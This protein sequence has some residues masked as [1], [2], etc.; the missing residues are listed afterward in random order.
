MGPETSTGGLSPNGTRTCGRRDGATPGVA[1]VCCAS[2]PPE[3]KVRYVSFDFGPEMERRKAASG[4]Y[5]PPEMSRVSFT[6][7][8]RKAIEVVGRE[9]LVSA[10]AGSGKTA[11]LAERCA[12][13]VCDAPADI[14][15]NVDELLVLTFT[16]AAAAEMRARIV[17]AI[18][19]RSHDRPEDA[20]LRE[21]LA[22]A[23]SAQIS[24]V[25]SF[26]LWIIR[27]WFT[28]AEVDPTASVLSAEEAALL[29]HE[30]MEAL[31]AALYARGREAE[32]P[33]AWER[34][35]DLPVDR[36]KSDPA[37]TSYPSPSGSAELL[38]PRFVRLVDDYGLG[39]DREIASL[40]QRLEEFTGSLPDPDAWF[41]NSLQRLNGNS[42]AVLAE[43][44][45]ELRAELERQLEA[46]GL[47]QEELLSGPPGQESYV[48]RIGEYVTAMQTW[49]GIMPKDS[50]DDSQAAGSGWR[51]SHVAIWDAVQPLILDFAFSKR[52]APTLPRDAPESQRAA[53]EKA[54]KTWE[55]VRKRM[56]Q[57]RIRD[58]FG[59]FSAREWTDGLRRIASAAGTLVDLVCAFRSEYAA[60]KQAMHVVDFADLERL[61]NRVIREPA[62]AD[63]LR[64]RFRFVL[65]DE[66]QD[67]NPLQEAIIRGVCRGENGR[68]ENL[69]AVGDIKQSIYR[70]R[71]AEPQV[72]AER[73][74]QIETVP[75]L[76]EAVFLQ[77]NFRS[78]PEILDAVN[79]VF[80]PLMSEDFGRLAY[81]E[82]VELRAGA[83]R[84]PTSP[85]VPVELHLIE[86]RFES[87]PS[88][89]DV[90]EEED[91]SELESEPGVLSSRDASR[92]EPIER[93][94]HLI[95][96]L[97]R[98]WTQKPSAFHSDPG[99]PLSRR[100]MVILLRSARIHAD[101]VAGMLQAMGIP[102][103]ADAGS[104][105]LATV[106]VRDLLAAL[107]VLDNPR[108][109][110]P[111]ASALRSGVFGIA[112]TED[113]LVALRCVDRESAFHAAVQEF[114]TRESGTEL[115]GKVETFWRRV[116]RLRERARRRPLADV[117]TDLYSEHGN[118]ARVAAMPRGFQRQTNLHRLHDLARRFGNFR[119]Q[120]LH[121][122][123]RFVESLDV[124]E[125]G[126][127]VAEA[128]S[129][130]EDA[131]RI[132]TIHQ[133]KG[134][135]F[136]VV[137][138]AGLGNSFNLRDRRS[139][140]IFER[141]TGLG[142][143]VV[144]R[145]RMIEYPT[146]AHL[147]AAM[148]LDRTA[149]EEELRILYVA[150]TRAMHR[151]VLTGSIRD[152]EERTRLS[153]RRRGR[154]PTRLEIVAARTPLDWLL[155]ALA[156]SPGVAFPGDARA[157][158]VLCVEVHADDAKNWSVEAV[159]HESNAE[160]R[161]VVARGEPLPPDEPLA[162]NDA[163]VAAV[164]RRLDFEYPWAHAASVRSVMA[165]SEFRG[166]LRF[167]PEPAPPRPS[168]GSGD[169]Q[170]PHSAASLAREASALKGT[171]T[172]R[173]L[174]H[175]SF[176][177]PPTEGH[178]MEQLARLESLGRLKREEREAV[179][180]G[181]IAWFLSTPLA[182]AIRRAA[183][184]YRRE[185]QFVVPES[186]AWFDQTF[187]AVTEDFVLVRGI[188]DG[189][190]PTSD[191]LELVD[192]K[193]DAV[194]PHDALNRAEQ[195]RPQMTMYARAVQ[196]LF[197]RPVKTAW[198]VF[199]DARRMVSLDLAQTASIPSQ[200]Q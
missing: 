68:C 84:E 39:E 25:H 71:L 37:E 110:I 162:T 66:F 188:I 36:S 48:L 30:T 149:R 75:G 117:L 177:E 74:R 23:D 7:E 38:G 101:R 141:R 50:A 9:V 12:H 142:L 85:R 13:L 179:D 144:D 34:P 154:P 26:C 147:L 151:L 199:L 65:V 90:E 140:M 28:E 170:L 108:Q 72:F 47:L 126:L 76:G 18:R 185:F 5:N 59:R 159:P 156:A 180:A 80:R 157:D 3:V 107:H 95:G 148:E 152:A 27:R 113:E 40:V 11:V 22:L 164:E 146:A 182:E 109:D 111:L 184:G 124:Q 104:D 120:G 14:R 41:E 169:F 4:P 99:K 103:I 2:S 123:L 137:F 176:H 78:R 187:Q 56:F 20:R 181:G 160:L 129:P 121:R 190:L 116:A 82:R 19:M 58:R 196:R 35:F 43:L 15:C 114:T 143:R 21:Q 145:E 192:Y 1:M 191:G 29:R 150:M 102:A 200:P 127:R 67:I 63:P 171:A 45:Q 175:L 54:K 64:R 131:V 106:E 115:A 183:D 60:R 174:Q 195:Y 125:M 119:R 88:E 97:I 172:H 186:P 112:L 194:K 134:L 122:F 166:T 168:A 6:P 138:L 87:T 100:D 93:E 77:R 79:L 57:E 155:P 70:F 52:R 51:D 133:S 86:R 53:R 33:A 55:D 128:M 165:A 118:L 189:I 42:D 163:A 61:A 10:A 153:Q 173:V 32:P 105:F 16:E 158:A 62:A 167:G 89:S 132:L 44:L 49:L 96:R 24:T 193:T 94:A 17:S 92:W 198:L 91:S 136:P 161:G 46:C 135:E 139:R 31:F 98:E 197:R 178:V 73:L 83:A 8:Q 130:A 69:F 81:D